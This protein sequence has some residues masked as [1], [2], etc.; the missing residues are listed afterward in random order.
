MAPMAEMRREST[1]EPL[2]CQYSTS[3]QMQHK[4]KHNMGLLILQASSHRMI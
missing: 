3:C 1:F 4:M 2:E